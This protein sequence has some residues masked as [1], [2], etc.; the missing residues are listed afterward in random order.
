MLDWYGN[1]YNLDKEDSICAG[2]VS[3]SHSTGEQKNQAKIFTNLEGINSYISLYIDA[4][5]YDC[6]PFRI[7]FHGSWSISLQ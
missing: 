1:I 2:N 5:V 4:F 7:S 6:L 3:R